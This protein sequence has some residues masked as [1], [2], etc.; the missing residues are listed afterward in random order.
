MAG[1]ATQNRE[2]A[3]QPTYSKEDQLIRRL[4]V[5]DFLPFQALQASHVDLENPMHAWQKAEVLHRPAEP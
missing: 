3:L 5:V 1:G 2:S 4:D